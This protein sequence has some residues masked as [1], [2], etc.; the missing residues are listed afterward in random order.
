MI[1]IYTRQIFSVRDAL[2]CGDLT[3]HK[4][5]LFVR[6]LSHKS[7]NSI[8]THFYQSEIT[9]DTNLT[10]KMPAD[11]A[12]LTTDQVYTYIHTHPSVSIHM[13]ICYPQPRI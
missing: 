2:G 7:I 1:H 12:E 4:F 8:I 11:Q 6:S 10:I 5:C 13:C 9:G 3:E